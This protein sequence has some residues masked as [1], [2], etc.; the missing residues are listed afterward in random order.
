MSRPGP[1]WSTALNRFGYGAQ[2]REPLGVGD[3]REALQAELGAPDAG[4]LDAGLARKLD[5]PSAPQAMASLYAFNSRPKPPPPSVPVA[6]PP[7]APDTIGETFRAEAR[8]RVEAALGAKIGFVERLVAFWSNHFCVVATK[9]QPVRILSGAFEREAIR[10]FV[11][12]RFADMA[13][14]VESHPAM[15]H[16]LD[17]A[18]S[19]G[20]NSRAGQHGKRGLNENLAREILELHT[21]GVES[22]YSQADVTEMARIL[23][24]W[25][26]GDKDGKLG[27]AGTFVFNA[28]AHEPG[29]RTLLGRTYEQADVAQGQMALDDLAR[30]PATASHIAHKF[31]SAFVADVPPAELVARLSEIFTRTDG[32]LRAL[33]N[34]LITDEVAW[35]APPAKMRDPWQLT[36]ASHR[37]LG[38]DAARPGQVLYLLNLLGQPLW[39]PGG[40]NGFP[41]TSAAWLS[42]EGIKMRI[43]VAIS[44]ARQAKEAPPP[45]EL[46][47]RVL[48]DA[49]KDTSEAVVRCETPQQA[50]TV[51]LMA[52]E[53]QRR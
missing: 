39:A 29:R 53:F 21:L 6:S 25:T 1:Q 40:P 36:M 32:D 16:Y 43:E 11:L 2:G 13:R 17:Q 19:V 28:N 5:L 24:G 18:Q 31:A 34:V 50:Y 35:S 47:A 4:L 45:R 42:A 10:P 9:S 20:P 33:A 8:A 48:P 51:L 38:L 12:G 15:L 30:H 26:A 46:L 23:T 44:L 3:A 27:P 41:D 52:P 37:A 14:A 22:G 7:M 49:S